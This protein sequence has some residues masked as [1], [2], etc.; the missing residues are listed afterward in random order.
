MR[1]RSIVG[2][3]SLTLTLAVM[4]PVVFV[5]SRGSVSTNQYLLIVGAVLAM[6]LWTIPYA[7]LVDP[8]LRR[9]LGALLQVTIEWHGTSKSMSWSAAEKAGCLTD[10]FLYLL[11]YLFIILWLSPLAGAIALVWWYRH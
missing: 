7:T 9:T 11:G 10:L 6:V 5:L 3:V 4:I 1:S 8:W 2:I